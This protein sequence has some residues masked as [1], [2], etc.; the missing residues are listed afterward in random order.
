[1]NVYTGNSNIAAP[2]ESL[3]ANTLQAYNS[4]LLLRAVEEFVISKFTT[5]KAQPKFEGK[6]AVFSHYDQIPASA[7][8]TAVL[9]DGVTPTAVDMTKKSVECSLANYGAF[10]EFSD[11]VSLYHEDGKVL[12]KEATDNLGS[13][14]GTAIEG[15]LFAELEANAGV[16]FLTVPEADTQTGLDKAE[17]Q[18]RV[19]LAKKFKSM[20]TGSKNTDTKTIR[21]CYVAF[22]NP[23]DV[24]AIEALPGFVPVNEYGYSDGLIQ[25]ETGSRRG[26]RFVESNNAAAGQISIL[27]E[28]ALA[29]VSI[30]SKGKMQTYVEGYGSAGSADPLHQRQTVGTT[31]QIAP[32][33]LRPEWS[34]IAAIV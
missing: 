8:T 17:T 19:N 18:L 24:L 9:A 27:G 3:S 6:K 20:I 13:G 26:L 11:E 34:A 15:L 23:S 16:D 4:R 12:V 21:E 28:E 10:T 14:A 2:A 22:F 31:F 33:L 25:N 7:F 32:K 30:R 29:E 5:K 1:M